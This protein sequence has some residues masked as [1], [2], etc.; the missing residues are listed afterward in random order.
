MTSC[1]SDSTPSTEDEV[2]DAARE[3]VLA[4]GATRTTL[5]E[6]ARRSGRSRPTIYSRWPD[7]TTLLT[8]LLT[9]EM[10][11]VME[12]TEP[13]DTGRLDARA[14]MSH[15]V[16]AIVRALQSDPLMRKLI[17]VDTELLSTYV[18]E[19]LGT[20]Q[21]VGLRFLEQGIRDGQADGS[22]RA[23][24]RPALA[25]MLLLVVQSFVH[26][27]GLVSE[28]LP[29]DTLAAELHRLVDDYLRP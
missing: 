26:S 7:V 5:T 18:F 17:E 11:S 16:V 20:S 14:R 6:I 12:A 15:H 19:R 27:G 9:R 10:L 25:A 4:F 28:Q 2:L 22:V 8:D 13:P 1:K 21:V 3:C 29:A 24:D 23:G